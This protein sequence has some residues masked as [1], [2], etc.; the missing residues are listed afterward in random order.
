MSR[1]REFLQNREIDQI[2]DDEEF[3]KEEYDAIFDYCTEKNFEVSEDDMQEI[4]NRGLEDSFDFWKNY[5]R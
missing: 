4:I 5:A 3:C 2:E 1:L